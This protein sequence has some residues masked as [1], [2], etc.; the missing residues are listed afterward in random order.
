MPSSARERRD[1]NFTQLSQMERER[2]YAH[3]RRAK[4]D[5]KER[6]RRSREKRLQS[7]VCLT[8]FTTQGKGK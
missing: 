7:P 3:L 5:I 2:I 1:P 8:Y 4:K 6:R